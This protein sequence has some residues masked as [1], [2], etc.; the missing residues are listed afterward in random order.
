MNSFN[1]SSKVGP[2][3]NVNK[4]FNPDVYGTSNQK[5]TFNIPKREFGT[6]D[7]VG[8]IG[9]SDYHDT[10]LTFHLTCK[11]V[12]I[13]LSAIVLLLLLFDRLNYAEKCKGT[14][15]DFLS[16]WL[17]KEEPSD[18]WLNEKSIFNFATFCTYLGRFLFIFD[19]FRC[20]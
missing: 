3:I 5:L 2:T 4:A 18:F 7:P 10:N 1:S 11:I 9:V 13:S 15:F 16:R 6:C 20:F 17:K 14:K 8:L 12:S 19:K